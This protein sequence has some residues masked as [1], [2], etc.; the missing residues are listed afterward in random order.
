MSRKVASRLLDPAGNAKCREWIG[1][2]LTALTLRCCCIFKGT[3]NRTNAFAGSQARNLGVV[4]PP[5]FT[6][7]TVPTPLYA[8]DSQLTSITY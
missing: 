8:A 5:A 3:D 4:H 7:V 6:L 2:G 1:R